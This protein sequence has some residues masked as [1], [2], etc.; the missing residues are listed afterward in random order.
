MKH[1]HARRLF[2]AHATKQT[3][4][5]V[6]IERGDANPRDLAS[7]EHLWTVHLPRII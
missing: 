2:A 1:R 5:L 6:A 3:A 4:E 7:A